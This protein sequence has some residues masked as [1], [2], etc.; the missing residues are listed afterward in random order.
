MKITC[1]AENTSSRSDIEAE[2]GLSLYIEANGKRILFDMGQGTLF[3][4]NAETLGIDISSVD[5]AVISHGHYDHGGGLSAFFGINKKAPVYISEHA[6]GYYYNANDKYI[7]L[8]MSLCGS[9]RFVFTDSTVSVFD[10][11]KLYVHTE[12]QKRFD[13]L[14]SGLTARQTPGSEPFPDEFLHE[15]YLCI[16]EGG[17]KVLFSGCSHRGVLNIMAR[18]A[19]DVFIGGLH[20]SKVQDKN[21]L[22]SHADILSRYKTRIYTCH[23]TGEEQFAEMKKAL[24]S[25]SYLRAGESI[26]I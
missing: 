20:L 6:F 12:V 9:D 25:L 26:I 19:P 8:D 1:L 15:Q 21:I 5:A 23:C 2:H 10:N 18:F 16:R 11:A 24:G 4:K 7:G 13:P 3:L 14:G 22:L 17:K